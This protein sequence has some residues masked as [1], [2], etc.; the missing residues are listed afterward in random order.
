MEE[1]SKIQNN[2]LKILYIVGPLATGILT[3]L[4][5]LTTELIDRCDITIAYGVWPETPADPGKCFDP[6]VKLIR[7]ENFTRELN[8]KKDLAAFFEIR[9]IASQVNPDVIHLHSSKAGALG[10]F[11]FS[12]KKVRLFYTP[13]GYSFLMP[14]KK[15]ILYHAVEKLCA[16]WDCRTLACC[17]SELEEALKLSDNAACIDNGIDVS[18]LPSSAPG[19]GV[20]T[21]GRISEQK[22]PAL[23]NEIALAM[24]DLQFTWIGAGPDEDKLT[25]PNIHVT[26]WVSREEAVR[27][28][29]QSKVFVLPS[30]WEGLSISLL[31]AMYMKK[32][33]VVS[34]IPGNRN[35]INPSNGFLCSSVDDYVQAIRSEASDLANRAHEDVCESFQ[36]SSMADR[37][38]SAYQGYVSAYVRNAQEGPACY[39]RVTQYAQPDWKLNSAYSRTQYRKNFDMAAG[40]ARKCYQAWL[41]LVTLKNRLRQLN[42]DLRHHPKAV[43]IQREMVPKVLPGFIERKMKILSQQTRII[44][45]F[46]DDIRCEG[47]CSAREYALLEEKSERIFVTSE[48]LRQ[49]ISSPHREKVALLPTTCRPI[50]SVGGKKSADAPF[51]VLWLGSFSSLPNLDLVGGMPAGCEFTVVCNKP[52]PKA[53]RNVSWTRESGIRALQNADVG[54]MP[55]IDKPYNYGKGGFKLIQYMSA[56]LPVIASP[57]GFN[58]EI[59]TPDFGIL[60]DDFPSAIA[61]LRDD[62]AKCAAMGAAARAAYESRFSFKDNQTVWKSILS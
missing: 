29:S 1:N 34:D 38:Y 57:I 56:G 24:P 39:Y 21:C 62:P 5:G 11:A 27:L 9:R 31:E 41:L 36:I 3:Y 28:A 55:L 49:K 17:R 59:V 22:N 60:T 33:C 46:D 18:D 50:P 10:R 37:Y 30:Q 23:F 47:E 51:K 14:G 35:A 52:W 61:E 13:H 7:V 20:Y 45:D 2:K 53:D 6:G 4:Q 48:Y 25:A 43:I 54:I 44:W 26:G 58:K 8:L 42:Y 16:A 12:G 32:L 40:P 15:S 19:S